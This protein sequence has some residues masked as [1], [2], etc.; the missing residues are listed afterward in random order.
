MRVLQKFIFMFAMIVGLSV[1]S[2]AQKQDP[3][4]PPPKPPPP[5]INPGDNKKPPKDDNKKPHKPDSAM[6]FSATV[7]S[8]DTA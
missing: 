3:K 6:I 1:V 5:V 4:K 7:R 2:F 8:D